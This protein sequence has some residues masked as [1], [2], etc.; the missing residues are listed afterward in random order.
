MARLV[1]AS[2]ALLGA[3]IT[4]TAWQ[5]AWPAPSGR[6][7]ANA[8]CKSCHGLDGRSVAPGIPNLAGQRARY[9]SKTFEEF[10]DGSR[11]HASLQ[12]LVTGLSEA[13]VGAVVQYYSDLA[14]VVPK[15]TAQFDA[16]S[17]G[18]ELAAACAPC[19]GSEGNSTNVGVPNLAGQQAK[20]LFD[21]TQEYMTGLRQAAPMNPAL[22]KLSRLDV[23]SLALYFASQKPVAS[24]GASSGDASRGER[25]STVCSGCHGARGVSTDSDTPSL[26]GQD[27]QYLERSMQSYRSDRRKND[28]MSRMLT[29][30]PD[31]DV[32]DLAAFYSTQAAQ[33]A[34]EGQVL[35]AQTVAKCDRCHGD[36][37]A[38]AALAI[39]I[40]ADQD[41]D[42][43][44]MALRAYR[45]GK[46]GNSVMHYMSQPYN[47][48]II[49]SMASHYAN[50]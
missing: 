46:R 24:S 39:P 33:P 11:V 32:G 25:L 36:I 17:R 21:A 35:V 44:V 19:H 20:Y 45:D 6:S 4:A 23:E 5:S 22:G 18:R 14:P 9:L 10:R 27:A 40:I 50:Q 49:E 37:G 31:S 2:L 48:A 28:V 42:Y 43:L 3:I 16:Y 38:H 29:T 12:P 41:K 7:I 47:D 1:W 26:A 34:E 30:M 15:R 8:Q 13:E